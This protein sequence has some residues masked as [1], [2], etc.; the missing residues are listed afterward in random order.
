[1]ASPP[2][3]AASPGT[4]ASTSESPAQGEQR[5]PAAP[6]P[7]FRPPGASKRAGERI[8][9]HA[10]GAAG[11]PSEPWPRQARKNA[12]VQMPLPRRR[13]GPRI[14]HI[15][16]APPPPRG[17]SALPPAEATVARAR[18]DG[19][20]QWTTGGVLDRVGGPAVLSPA[21]PQV[22]CRRGALHR[23]GGPAVTWPDGTRAW[24]EAGVPHRADGPA[25]EGTDRKEW[26]NHGILHREG[27]RGEDIGPAVIGPGG[28]RAWYVAGV[29][30]RERPAGGGPAG[31]ALITADGTQRW[32]F[33]GI[34][35]REDGPAVLHRDG[36]PSGTPSACGTP[37]GCPPAKADCASPGP[38]AR[39]WPG[40]FRGHF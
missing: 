9:K 11:V 32:Y 40:L 10:G 39:A 6:R 23:E 3:T 12:R 35:H 7:G 38:G 1:M 5:P 26:R 13:G 33:C 28:L 15:T 21:G 14:Q 16:T 18:P 31:P 19:T 36:A 37:R 27:P 25:I 30:H 29:L 4:P 20:L 2:P 24:F 34:L 8:C 17:R 22:W